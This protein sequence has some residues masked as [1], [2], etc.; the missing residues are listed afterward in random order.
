MA[1]EAGRTDV[2]HSRRRMLNVTAL[3]RTLEA[4]ITFWL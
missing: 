2:Q 4:D 3:L 1:A